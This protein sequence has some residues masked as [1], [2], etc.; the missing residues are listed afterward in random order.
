MSRR[1]CA[2]RRR[3][4]RAGAHLCRT[5]SS[6]QSLLFPTARFTVASAKD[7]AAR[8][9]WKHDD[10]D[11]KSDFIHLRQE[12]PAGFKKVRTVYMGGSGVQARVGWKKC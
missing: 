4:G 6:V 12:D 9:S 5:A 3:Y 10:V 7:W 11:I 8:H 1:A 2:L